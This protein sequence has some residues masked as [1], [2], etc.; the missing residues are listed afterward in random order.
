MKSKTQASNKTSRPVAEPV[1]LHMLL[2]PEDIVKA[3][4]FP[5]RSRSK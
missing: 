5:K 1:C 3:A 2:I 4:L